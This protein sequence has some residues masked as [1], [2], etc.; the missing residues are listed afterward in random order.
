MVVEHPDCGHDFPPEIRQAAY[1]WLDLWL[2]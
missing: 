1:D 2:K